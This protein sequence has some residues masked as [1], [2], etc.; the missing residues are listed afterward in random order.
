VICTR[1]IDIAENLT[2]I[3][4]ART[5]C[6]IVKMDALPSAISSLNFYQTVGRYV[7]EC[8]DHCRLNSKSDQT[9]ISFTYFPLFCLSAFYVHMFF[10][11]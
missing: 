9:H 7:A 5:L 1:F 4:H 10:F 11:I 8:H 3:F 2:A 6:Y